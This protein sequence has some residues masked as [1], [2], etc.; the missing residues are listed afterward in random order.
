MDLKKRIEKLETRQ[1][2]VDPNKYPNVYEYEEEM[3][4][5]EWN[6]TY[7][8]EFQQSY[9]RKPGASPGSE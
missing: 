5:E 4:E 1:Q 8:K 2:P 7:A 3:M 6:A 9:L